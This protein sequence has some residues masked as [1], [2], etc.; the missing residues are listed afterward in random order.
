MEGIDLNPSGSKRVALLARPGPAREQLRYALHEAGADIVLED[1][2]GAME[3][4][5][6][7]N[8]QPQV[9]LVALEPAVEDSLL[10][11]AD[12]LHDP[13]VS[14][15]YDEADLA[16]RRSGWDA[17]RWARHLS[18]KL[19]GHHDVLPPGGEI[20]DSQQL[21]PGKPPSPGQSF[22]GDGFELYLEEAVERGADLP[23]DD[24]A[25]PP[26]PP[27]EL[28][29]ADAWLRGPAVQAEVKEES[30]APAPVPEAALPPPVPA[31]K[32]E[33]SL[34]PLEVTQAAPVQV[35]GAVLV[36][37]GIGGPDAVRKLLGGLDESFGKPLLVHLQLDGGRYD[38]LVRQMARATTMPVQ[39]AESG[40]AAEPG[41]VYI[42][43]NEVELQVDQGAVSFRDGANLKASIAQL[44][45][46]DS[47]VLLLSGSDGALVEPASLLAQQGG[48]AMGQSQEGCYDPS[49][50]LA[51]AARGASLAAPVQIA[52]LLAE[53]WAG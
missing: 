30:P 27:A 19:H 46:A 51:L 29:D 13:A 15:I 20:D 1:D 50:A 41:H 6:L 17:Q 5:T 39:L 49:A 12:V 28:V 11:L 23:R 35:S 25:I 10:Q 24:F 33:L 22:N 2:P 32:W 7:A 26:L 42:L 53:R 52:Q 31:T 43:S 4:Q 3:L 48:L 38:N 44:P 40:K 36:F 47:A 21:E 34:E 14:V 37:A 18:A 16:A 45:A 8:A 9:V